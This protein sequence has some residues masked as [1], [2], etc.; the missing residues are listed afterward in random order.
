MADFAWIKLWSSLPTHRKSDALEAALA[1]P[2]AWTHLVELWLWAI[3]NAADGD[4]SAVADYVIAKRAGWSGDPAK[5]VEALTSTGWLSEDR[6]MENWVERQPKH[7]E[8]RLKA[9]LKK[10]A[11]RA[12]SKGVR[13]AKPKSERECIDQTLSPGTNVDVPRDVPTSLSSLSSLSSSAGEGMQGEGG[14]PPTPVIKPKRS[15]WQRPDT[16]DAVL[17][18]EWA[19]ETLGQYFA[20]AHHGV[21]DAV[22]RNEIE[23]ALAR[24]PTLTGVHAAQWGQHRAFVAKMKDWVLRGVQH[25]AKFGTPVRTAGTGGPSEAQRTLAVIRSKGWDAHTSPESTNASLPELDPTVGPL[26][27]QAAARAAAWAAKM[28]ARA[29]MDLAPVADSARASRARSAQ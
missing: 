3:N 14:Y 20:R 6:I 10:R 11:Q 7:V 1:T 4:L 21:P 28:E 29:A 17:A 23:K 2:R 18:L 5:F 15:R 16:V 13:K 25:H 26:F 24:I 19:K 9:T 12:T 22:T 8:N 27:A